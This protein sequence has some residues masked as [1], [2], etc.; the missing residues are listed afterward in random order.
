MILTSL[1][2]TAVKGFLCNPWINSMKPKRDLQ[3]LPAARQEEEA[4]STLKPQPPGPLFAAVA[5][6]VSTLAATAVAVAVC[7]A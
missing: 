3:Q 5:V 6:T 1:C 4:A 2:K 7:T